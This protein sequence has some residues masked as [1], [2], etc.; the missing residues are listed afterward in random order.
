MNNYRSNRLVVY[1]S[2]P[3]HMVPRA[4]APLPG[5]ANA[6]TSPCRSTRS[7]R[8]TCGACRS[9][10][11]GQPASASSGPDATARAD[12][13]VTAARSSVL[14]PKWLQPGTDTML[15]SRAADVHPVSSLR[16][17]DRTVVGMTIETMRR[18]TL[19]G[20]RTVL[21]VSFEERDTTTVVARTTTQVDASSLLPIRQR[22]E[23]DAG[24]VV[25]LL[26]TGQ[27]PSGHRLGTW[28]VAALLRG[29]GGRHGI[30]FGRDRS[31]TA[32]T[33]A[34]TGLPRGAAYLLPGGRLRGSTPRTRHRA[35]AHHDPRWT[36]S[37]LLARCG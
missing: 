22:A 10:A 23:L 28:P 24:Q 15:M 13:P 33:A 11:P 16:S 6:P 12:G 1:L 37:G 32:S 4:P 17:G 19:A 25:I 26:Y 36:V 34:R 31:A 27:T 2:T 3:A 20:G 30:Q 18:R 14:D 9:V 5:P 7:H 29:A 21:E 35:G 8:R